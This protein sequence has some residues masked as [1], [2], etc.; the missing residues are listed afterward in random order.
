VN[1]SYGD[2]VLGSVKIV[3][4]HEETGNLLVEMR[5]FFVSDLPGIG[6]AL[7][8]FLGG[9]ASFDKDRSYVSGIKAFPKNV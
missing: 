8:G 6:V 4:I 3:S 7:K 9:A 1:L 2:S 5:T